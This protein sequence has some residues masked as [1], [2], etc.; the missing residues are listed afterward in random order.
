M[1]TERN[2]FILHLDLELDLE[3]EPHVPTAKP[4]LRGSVQDVDL[5]Q[6]R[7]FTRWS[8]LSAFC[9]THR[10]QFGARRLIMKPK[11]TLTLLICM[12]ATIFFAMAGAA[13]A[14][15]FSSAGTSYYSVTRID[16][17]GAG[18]DAEAINNT[19]QVTGI[20]EAASGDDHAF[21]WQNGSLT[22]LGTLGGEDTRS[23][24]WDINN[25]GKVVGC[26]DAPDFSKDWAVS[27][28]GSDIS[29]ELWEGCGYGINA[30]NQIVG[31]IFLEHQYGSCGGPL[32]FDDEDV[33]SLAM[34]P[35]DLCGWANAINASGQV[36]GVSKP[37]FCPC[38]LSALFWDDGAL[39]VLSPLD[40]GASEAY[41]INDSGLIVGRSQ[42][43]AGA[44][45]AVF[46][47][48]SAVTDINPTESSSSG[49][50]AVNN[51]GQ[52][53]IAAVDAPYLWENGQFARL[54]QAIDPGSDWDLSSVI[55]INDS[56]WILATGSHPIHESGAIIL[57]PCPSC[58]PTPT[59]TPTATATPKVIDLEVTGMEITQGI[60][61]LDNEMPLV[62]GRE[63]FIRVYV[64]ELEYDDGTAWA[65]GWL[66]AFDDG[67]ELTGSPIL[68]K[69]Q[70]IVVEPGGGSRLKPYDSLL[71]QLPPDWRDGTK[72]FEVEV[73]YDN[74]EVEVEFGNNKASRTV[75]FHPSNEINVIMV[76]LQVYT[77][78]GPNQI[79]ML[80]DFYEQ[81]PLSGR[82]LNGLLRYHPISQINLLGQ[83]NI[84][85]PGSDA[86]EDQ[87]DLNTDK[88]TILMNNAIQKY[89]SLT[90]D[91][92]SDL[93]YVG[94][95]NPNAKPIHSGRGEQPGY[96]SWVEMDYYSWAGWNDD[97]LSDASWYVDGANIMAH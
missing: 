69:D 47:S 44:Y 30:N 49:A 57:K 84:V 33:L 2:T 10:F 68:A 95:V 23:W 14:I 74:F 7:Y 22:D 48:L 6:I 76:P 91:P 73:N 65:S 63:T 87:W 88:D 20:F 70:G 15:R 80:W 13:S 42:D 29:A 1:P 61:N 21:R 43:S 55:D 83:T 66:R 59:P 62:A 17:L 64:E 8:S 71:F 58:V 78:P 93:Y 19:G 16:G 5:Q 53:L 32:I 92:V 94:M 89:N 85:G 81:Q 18:D 27:W 34:K 31:Y 75:T 51:L 45:H 52:V 72:T 60:Q 28:T 82:V 56:G 26:A 11:L 46:W 96:N 79:D 39:T 12:A 36:V 35:G 38:P 4:G 9:A 77:E 40:N 41:D 86:P 3:H 90:E 25:S 54:D 24:A 37:F 67:V 50:L 97:D